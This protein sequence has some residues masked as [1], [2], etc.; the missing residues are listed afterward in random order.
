L[1]AGRL[2]RRRESVQLARARTPARGCGRHAR[3]SRDPGARAPVLARV[4]PD[5]PDRR[6]PLRAHQPEDSVQMNQTATD[7]DAARSALGADA[8]G[9]VR[10]P[11]SEFWRK[12]KKQKIALFA[13]GFVVLLVV[14][15]ILAPWI[16]PYDAENYFDYDKLNAPPSWQ[17]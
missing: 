10:S 11:S 4:H 5:Q 2:D 9:A 1:P 6:R 17:H 12:F 8:K 15:A 7:F 16:V 13:G 3:L 14:V